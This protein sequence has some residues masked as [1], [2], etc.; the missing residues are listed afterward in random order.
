MCQGRTVLLL[1]CSWRD[2]W[3]SGLGVD[4][5][6]AI[7]WKFVKKSLRFRKHHTA[8]NH[9]RR[10]RNSVI[11]HHH[12]RITA[13]LMHVGLEGIRIELAI[14]GYCWNYVDVTLPKTNSKSS[15]NAGETNR[16]FLFQGSILRCEL[17]VSGRVCMSQQGTPEDILGPR[18]S[19]SLHDCDSGRNDS[20]VWNGW[21]L[22]HP[23][24]LLGIYLFIIYNIQT[25]L[26]FW[27][28]LVFWA[29][30]F[31]VQDAG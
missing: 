13:S 28:F 2:S 24:D 6:P 17:L 21:K 3:M 1:P 20:H 19:M 11:S 5:N 27:K 29:P 23:R 26:F 15:K 4:V 7:G 12:G 9:R 25:G 31:L 18:I 30:A 10:N 14:S 8:T 16:S 22:K